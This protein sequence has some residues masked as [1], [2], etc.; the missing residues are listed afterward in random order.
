[1]TPFPHGGKL[2]PRR[3]EGE[4]AAALRRRAAGL[5]SLSLDPIALSDLEMFAGGGFSPLTGFMCAADYERVLEEMRLA[6]GH[7]WPIPIT[8][9]VRVEEAGG[10]R[11]G[12]EVALRD[13]RG[14][15]RGSMVVAEIFPWSPAREAK[16]VFGTADEAHPG[17]RRLFKLGDRLAGGEVW[18]LPRM[19]AGAWVPYLLDPAQ[20]RAEFARRGWRTVA[21]F[22]TRNPLH[23]GHEY[24]QKVV[25]ETVDGILLHPITGAAEEDG[26]PADVRLR[27]YEVLLANYF[28]PER[29]LLSAMPGAMRHAGPREAVLHALIGKNYGCTHF[30]LGRDHAGAGDFHRPFAAQEI[31]NY[32]GQEELGIKLLFFE[33]AFFCRVCGGMAT[34]KTCPHGAADRVDPSVTVVRAMLARGEAPPAEF[35]R[36]EVSAVLLAAF[37]QARGANAPSGFAPGGS[38]ASGG[39]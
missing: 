16:M 31:F 33:S 24:I 20:T 11:P 15:L 10:L 28:P 5:P 21:G 13:G 17:V 19:G 22:Q 35:M 3:L 32:F 26:L 38:H 4:E 34:R 36:P 39:R 1:M 7:V 30:I 14:R 8:L 18:V 25:L 27:C 29:V 23:R 9:A 6:K 37:T 2:V 12:Q